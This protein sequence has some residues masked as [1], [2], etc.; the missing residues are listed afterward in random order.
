M[1]YSLENYKSFIGKP[2]SE[3]PTPAFV[4]SLPVLKQNIDNLHRDVEKLGIRFRPHVKTL[5]VCEQLMKEG[6]LEY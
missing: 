1:D 4:I 2:A 5:K 3:L 6:G